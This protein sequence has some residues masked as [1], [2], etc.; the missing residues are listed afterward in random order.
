[1]TPW[2]VALGLVPILLLI[3]KRSRRQR[4]RASRIAIYRSY[5]IAAADP[6]FAAEMREIE[7]DYDCTVAD[8]L[9]E[10]GCYVAR[11]ERG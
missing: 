4:R 6:D 10:A 7:A 2:I 5:G 3:R 9:G 1:M 11:V 8:G